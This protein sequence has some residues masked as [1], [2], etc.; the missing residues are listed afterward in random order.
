MSNPSKRFVVNA[1]W[2]ITLRWVAV[3]GQVLTILAVIWILKIEIAATGALAAV[4]GV[5]A[6]SNLLLSFWFSRNQPAENPPDITLGLVMVMDMLSLTC[7]LF[8]TGGPSNPFAFFFFVNLS[9][10]ALILNRNWA[11]ALNILSILCFAA[12]LF[13][14]HPIS[15]LDFGFALEPIRATGEVTIPQAGLL[16]AFSTCASVIVYFMTRLTS[17]L[18]QQELDLRRAQVV[19]ARSEKLEA[20]GTLAAG[21]A[22]ELATPLSTIAIVARDVEKAFDEHPPEFPGA[23]DVIEDVHLIRSQLD[24][25]R[26]I[27][28]RMAGQAG[29]AIGETLSQIT[30]KQLMEEILQE[31]PDRKRISSQ[32]EH[33]VSNAYVKVPLI[34]LS[35]ALRGLFQNALD[36]D[37]T[38]KIQLT[39]DRVHDRCRWV[40]EDRGEGM[41]QEVLQRLSEPFFTTKQPGKGMG[42]GVFLARNVIERLDGTLQFDSV[43]NQGTTVTFVLPLDNS[44]PPE[45]DGT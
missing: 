15:E 22:H 43:A 37:A 44:L 17:E 5:T 42:L 28:D 11:W 36:A 27:L 45:N 20:L 38:G 30:V 34:G 7:L 35:Q 29:Q 19:Q 3:I 33:E 31:L 4:I 26:N 39:V 10:C 18:R 2:L 24:R 1:S 32:F 23:E 6:I 41:T 9:L 40:L 14:H 13:Q 25:C 16:I 8:A 12:L 21:T